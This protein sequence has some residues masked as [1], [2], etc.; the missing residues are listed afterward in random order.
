M[1]ILIS[2]LLLMGVAVFAKENSVLTYII[3]ETGRP[4]SIDP[5]DA[6]Q[7]QNLPVARMLYATPVEL[8][9]S[10]NLKSSILKS[11]S[12]DTTTRTMKWQIK[13]GTTFSDGS[14]ITTRDIELAV[15]RM[16]H[17]RPGFPVI[18]KING[19][20]EWL[21]SEKPLEGRPSGIK[22]T[23]SEIT[24]QFSSEVERPL[25]RFSLEIFSIIPA[26]C[27]DLKT[28]KLL[29]ENI[30][31]SGPYIKG[32]DDG[33]SIV[34]KK[35][36]FSTGPFMEIADQIQFKYLTTSE[37]I[38]SLKS[39][40][41]KTIVAGNQIQ[42]ETSALSQLQESGK[43]VD[44]PAARFAA[45]QI[46]PTLKPFDEKACRFQVAEKFRENFAKLGK[47]TISPQSS[48]FTKLLPGYMS[49]EELRSKGSAENRKD[50]KKSLQGKEVNWGYLESES[51]GL[52]ASALRQTLDDLGI[53]GKA[54][55]FENRKALANAFSDG[56]IAFMGGSSGFW[57][58][59][60]AGDLQMLFTPN[61][62]KPLRFLSEDANLQTLIREAKSQKS[63]RAFQ[64]VNQYIY[65]LGL[66]NV[67]AHT[68]RFY[69]SRNKALLK[70]AR[71]G[72]TAP[73][74]WE[75]FE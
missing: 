25:V 43:K 18:E 53:V 5:L 20:A 64:A 33:K 56:L 63:A 52:F 7:T 48:L 47:N 23:K 9:S 29:C 31:S 68:R 46:N 67:Y 11:F 45:L 72:T 14:P 12:Y 19:A 38:S 37:F 10:D 49:Q 42:Y 51:T 6:D 65:D 55:S 40:D 8:D 61:L 16:I 27:I 22:S 58:F 71:F 75:V 41:D 17:A 62:H 3:T 15:T 2:A 57:A 73:A 13:E 54:K 26:K 39:I 24:I 50:C 44:L 59:D 34:F 4:T 70:E 74:P 21:R 35:R 36:S 1:R 66:F 30:P 69:W 32:S 28:G 60:P